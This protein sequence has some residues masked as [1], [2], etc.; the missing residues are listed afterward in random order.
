[1]KKFKN[2]FQVK[3]PI[4]HVVNFHRDTRTLKI[5]TPPPMVV[6]FNKIEPLAE[7]SI[8]DFIIW[9]GPIPVHWKAKHSDV[10]PNNGFIDTQVEGPFKYWVHRHSFVVINEGVTEVKDEIQAKFS[11][12]PYRGM[13]G[14]LMWVNLPT[15][16]A[17]RARK[18]R[19]E[20]EA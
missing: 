13:V 7:G 1:M 5:L 6:R 10:D 17:F 2:S 8:A 15:L 3:A 19:Q 9:L 11:R 18:T 20:L 4:E 12:H 16:F 14:R